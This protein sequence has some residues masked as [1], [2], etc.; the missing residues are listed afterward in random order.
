LINHEFQRSVTDCVSLIKVPVLLYQR[1]QRTKLAVNTC[2]YAA[3]LHLRSRETEPFCKRTEVGAD[4]TDPLHSVLQIFTVY[5]PDVKL[6][7][8]TCPSREGEVL[9]TKSIIRNRQAIVYLK[10][11]LVCGMELETLTLQERDF[12]HFGAKTT[13]P[14]PTALPKPP[15]KPAQAPT[16]AR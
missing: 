5:A 2:S 12:T 1:R 9:E 15:A 13:P 11:T 8:V 3:V 6:P 10:G 14:D 4:D 16:I 7:L